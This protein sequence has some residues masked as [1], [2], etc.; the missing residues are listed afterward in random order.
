MN[1][2]REMN[3]EI[4]RKMKEADEKG[5]FGL[6][7]PYGAVSW[8]SWQSIIVPRE[9]YA[10]PFTGRALALLREQVI[11][12]DCTRAELLY[13]REGLGE[14]A[15]KNLDIEIPEEP[16]KPYAAVLNEECEFQKNIGR[17][18][19]V[20]GETKH[21]ALKVG[22]DEAYMEHKFLPITNPERLPAI[23]AAVAPKELRAEAMK[24]VRE[25]KE[26]LDSY[27]SKGISPPYREPFIRTTI[28]ALYSA[29]EAAESDGV[30]GKEEMVFGVF[31]PTA[32][33]Y[34]KLDKVRLSESLEV[35]EVPKRLVEEPEAGQ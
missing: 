15:W 12:A 1:C 11:A 2:D 3:A 9:G 29:M 19:A 34:R 22:V 10:S 5:G 4:L 17:I 31:E 7:L 33:G 18:V 28:N 16:F 8:L 26:K 24:L 30:K 6:A 32:T 20:I 27:F 25:F 14:E 13:I 23:A 21:G 35:G